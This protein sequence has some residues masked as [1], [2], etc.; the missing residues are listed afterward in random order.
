MGAFSLACQENHHHSQ[1]DSDV[2]PSV[3]G[4]RDAP[5]L[6]SVRLQLVQRYGL[7]MTSVEVRTTLKFN[8]ASALSMARKRGH[9]KL[10]A[11]R[12]RGR[13]HLIF[14]TEDVAQ[15]IIDLFER[16]AGTRSSP[17]F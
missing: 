6:Q 9:L 8:S 3:D 10:T 14:Y 1:M 5:S 7:V 13:R 15:A 2:T 11:H 12:M 4:R 17:D 16:S